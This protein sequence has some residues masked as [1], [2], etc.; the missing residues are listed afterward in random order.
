M[1][2]IKG[3][4]FIRDTLDQLFP[5]PTVTLETHDDPYTLL[6]AVVLSARCRDERVNRVSPRL[7]ALARTPSAMAQLSAEEIEKIIRPCG[8]SRAKSTAIREM[9]IILCDVYGG[10]VPNDFRRL[11][12]LPGV[13][14]KTASVVLGRAF[15]LPTFPVDTHVHRLARR[16]HLTRGNSVTRTERDLKVLF[17]PHEWYKRHLQFIH[18]GRNYCNRQLC[19]EASFCRICRYVNA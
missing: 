8:L 19:Y 2:K 16:W 6:V 1:E 11:E 3:I 13:G 10:D 7:F 12:A 5:A 9:S 4:D 18:Y 14:H 15:G 17:P